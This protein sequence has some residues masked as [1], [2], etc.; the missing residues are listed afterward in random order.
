MCVCVT[1]SMTIIYSY[2]NSSC[3]AHI[4]CTQWVYSECNT[5]TV[6]DEST[7]I[8]DES[9]HTCEWVMAHIYTSHCTYMNESCHIC[10]ESTHI[11]TQH[12]STAHGECTHSCTHSNCTQ[13]HTLIC[14][15]H[16]NSTWSVT[17][18]HLVQH[19]SAVQDACTVS[20][21]HPLSQL[22]TLILSSTHTSTW[23]VYPQQL[24]TVTHTMYE[25]ALVLCGVVCAYVCVCV[26][27]AHTLSSCGRVCMSMHSRYICTY[28]CVLHMSVYYI[29]TYECVVTCARYICTYECVW[30]C[31][32]IWVC[33]AHI[34][35]VSYVPHTPTVHDQS[36]T[37]IIYSTQQLYTV[38]HAHMYSTHQQYV[39]SHTHS[40]CTA[41]IS[42]T[43]C[44]YSECNTSTVT[45]TY[46][47]LVQHTSTVQD[48][49]TVRVTHPLYRMSL[50]T[51]TVHSYTHSYVQL[52]TLSLTRTV[53]LRIVMRIG[54]HIQFSR[55]N[56][57]PHAQLHTLSLPRTVRMRIGYE[58]RS[59]E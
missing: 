10:D 52:H 21:T 46:T 19:T 43:G 30:V 53:H 35:S 33:T 34:N 5:S 44:V 23:C 13:L 38:T 36:H 28:E 48:E 31:M 50:H 45:V 32:Y 37:L 56:R 41:H 29:C 4:N 59:W 16:I 8:C 2:T 12:T 47:H 25:Y 54:H 51:R 6:H 15:A 27:R 22:H 57:L 9:W 24:Y 20:V 39:I 42:S 18:A 14:T 7:H 3:R 40:S 17:H 49:C 26:C 11:I 1:H 55:E 58:N